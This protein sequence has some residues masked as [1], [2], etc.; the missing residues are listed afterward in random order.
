MAGLLYPAFLQGINHLAV[1]DLRNAV[2]DDNHRTV[3]LD[4]VDGILDLFCGDGVQRSGGFVQEDDG[5]ILEEHAGDGNAL[6][7]AAGQV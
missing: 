5:R 1:N 3:L 4:G 6:L 2:G 7:L